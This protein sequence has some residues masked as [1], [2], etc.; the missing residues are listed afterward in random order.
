MN[1][2]YKYVPKDFQSGMPTLAEDLLEFYE[3]FERYKIT[4]VKE[5]ANGK[6]KVGYKQEAIQ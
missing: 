5:N 2:N 1:D 6:Q 4:K 3:A